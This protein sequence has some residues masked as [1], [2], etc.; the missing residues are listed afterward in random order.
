MGNQLETCWDDADKFIYN[1]KDFINCGA[2][3]NNAYCSCEYLTHKFSNPNP[4]QLTSSSSY[5]GIPFSDLS[6]KTYTSLTHQEQIETI[7]EK[8][9]EKKGVLYWFGEKANP[10]VFCEKTFDYGFVI[11]CVVIFSL[12]W[13]GFFC[14][15]LFIEEEGGQVSFF[16]M[17]FGGFCWLIIIACIY[18]AGPCPRGTSGWGRVC[19]DCPKGRYGAGQP[20]LLETDGHKER[21]CIE[22]PAGYYTSITRMPGCFPCLHGMYQDA[23]GKDKCKLCPL[24]GYTLTHTQKNYSIDSSAVGNINCMYC[25]PGKYMKDRTSVKGCEFCPIGQYNRHKE[26]KQ[27]NCYKCP[28]GF[29]QEQTGQA[30]CLQCKLG[31]YSSKTGQAS[32]SKCPKGYSSSDQ[33]D[34]GKTS[35]SI[36]SGGSYAAETG[37]SSCSL[38]PVGKANK[39]KGSTDPSA[40]TQCAAGTFSSQEGVA[41]CSECGAGTIST[42]AGNNE[43]QACPT[44]FFVEKSQQTSCNACQSCASAKTRVQLCGGPSAG[45]C[46]AC[47]PNCNKCDSPNKCVGLS[48]NECKNGTH[49]RC[50]SNGCLNSQYY[51]KFLC[52][53]NCLKFGLFKHQG[54]NS[55]N[56]RLNGTGFTCRTRRSQTA[57]LTFVY[58]TI[59]L[60]NSGNDMLVSKSGIL[61]LAN[62]IENSITARDASVG[63]SNVKV[64]D[65]KLNARLR[66]MMR[67]RLL[68]TAE[69]GAMT[70]EV[71]LSYYVALEP[72]KKDVLQQ[73]NAQLETW[74][75]KPPKAMMESI[76][77]LAGAVSVKGVFQDATTTVAGVCPR[78]FTFDEDTETCVSC[79]ENCDLCNNG[80]SDVCLVCSGDAYTLS[81]TKC[82]KNCNPGYERNFVQLTEE[83]SGYRCDLWDGTPL[84]VV[85][86]LL[87]FFGI[88]FFVLYRFNEKFHEFINACCGGCF[89]NLKAWADLKKTKSEKAKADKLKA[90]K[91]KQQANA[92]KTILSE[93]EEKLISKHVEKLKK[94]MK[95]RGSCSLNS[96][97]FNPPSF[98]P[99]KEL[100][101][102]TADDS[103]N[104]YGFLGM[105]DEYVEKVQSDPEGA[106]EREVKKLQNDGARRNDPKNWFALGSD[107]EEHK[108]LKLDCKHE[109]LE[110]W[111]YVVNGKVEVEKEK[112]MYPNGLRDKG[113]KAGTR[114]QDFME[115]KENIYNDKYSNE[116]KR[117]L[118]REHLIALRLYT[119]LLFKYI[120]APLRD[121]SLYRTYED[122]P[123]QPRHPL[124]AMVVFIQEGLVELRKAA[125]NKD[126]EVLVLWR[127]MTNV[128]VGR[129]FLLQGGSEK[130]PM[131]TTRDLNVALKYGIGLEYDSVL[132]RIKVT[133]KVKMGADLQW[134]SAFPQESE[135]LYPPLTYLSPDLID[136]KGRKKN[137]G[138]KQEIEIQTEK[139]TKKITIV[140]IQPDI[141]GSGGG[142]LSAKSSPNIRSAKKTTVEGK[143]MT[144]VEGKTKTTVEG[145]TGGSQIL[146]TPER[147]MRTR[148]LPESYSKHH[149]V[150]KISSS[151]NLNL[152]VALEAD[153]EE[154]N[155]DLPIATVTNSP[156]KRT[157][158]LQQDLE[159]INQMLENGS[160]TQEDFDKLK[161]E[162]FTNFRDGLKRS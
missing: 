46:D 38:C 140:Q 123:D 51:Y 72:E 162:L 110:L 111:N 117:A 157:M 27:Y 3:C 92:D 77:S 56:N 30:K 128:A 59:E 118:K 152:P 75:L 55:V 143:T 97:K 22:C 37:Q 125:K 16:I 112:K 4:P 139:G 102:G 126:G 54:E 160:I 120:N 155:R 19:Y 79:I 25:S 132:F 104:F 146:Q 24:G 74:T 33:S 98:T 93:E 91:L 124:A 147:P 81:G 88:M 151:G 58:K 53:S 71:S 129:E 90:K 60:L 57:A 62:I 10:S 159:G 43:C 135:V 52:H 42:A 161:E 87:F 156:S 145:S 26:N 17:S 2:C 116:K 153:E 138:K 76:V 96:G 28:I 29:Y 39:N 41:V 106:M 70:S 134:L 154:N 14:C 158:E 85:L 32:C 107:K 7:Q 20:E 103:L 44:G 149:I 1:C 94:E 13:C 101:F 99:T 48:I 15:G 8:C 45:R 40:C 61:D 119:T 18:F 122:Q 35:C 84:A 31:M 9:E 34:G 105:S 68:A 11:F 144:T 113:R 114:L 133:S 82:Y 12:L 131:S 136:T 23:P 78:T 73:L 141:V 121:R 36:C 86:S 65:K 49:I 100:I 47:P 5:A 95:R 150:P 80:D 21:I 127:G 69:D 142:T 67:Q 83:E 66:L 6:T 130:A 63:I 108:A 148:S 50:S 137:R 109:V 89:Y 115:K 64:P